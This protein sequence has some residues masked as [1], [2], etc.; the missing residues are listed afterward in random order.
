MT[1]QVHTSGHA[2][3]GSQHG[4]LTVTVYAP[5]EPDPKTFRFRRTETV[6]AAA[7]TAAQQFGYTSGTPSFQN[8]ADEVLDRNL[9]LAAAHVHNGDTLEVV[10]V[11]GGV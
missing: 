11:G 6:G 7:A 2:E 9:S 5:R 10:D 4:E 8:S 3:A 1:D